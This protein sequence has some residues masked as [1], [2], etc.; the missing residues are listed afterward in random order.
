LQIK[1][2][3]GFF[4]F[5]KDTAFLTKSPNLESYNAIEDLWIGAFA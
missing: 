3:L 1:I 4:Q 5:A 2:D